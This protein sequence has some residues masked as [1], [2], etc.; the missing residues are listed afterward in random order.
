MATEHFD[1]YISYR[2][3]DHLNLARTIA[4]LLKENDLNVWFYE[5]F[6]GD[7]DRYIWLK[8][9]REALEQCDT[10]V[11]LIGPQ[12]LGRGQEQE[13]ALALSFPNIRIIPVLTPKTSLSK[14]PNVLRNHERVILS[15]SFEDQNAQIRLIDSIKN[16]PSYKVIQTQG[17]PAIADTPIDMPV[18]ILLALPN[19]VGQSGIERCFDLWNALPRWLERLNPDQIGSIVRTHWWLPELAI[20]KFG[21]FRWAVEHGLVS[22]SIEDQRRLR[23]FPG[24]DR[25]QSQ[26]LGLKQIQQIEVLHF[27]GQVLRSGLYFGGQQFMTPDI[28][29]P[30]LDVASTRLLILSVPLANAPSARG[31][32]EQITSQ[33]G[34]AVLVVADSNIELRNAYFARLYDNLFRNL[35]YSEIIKPPAELEQPG[36]QVRSYCGDDAEDLFLFTKRAY[37]LRQQFRERTSALRN[38]ALHVSGMQRE[39]LSARASS[40][41]QAQIRILGDQIGGTQEFLVGSGRGALKNIDMDSGS[42]R[43]FARERGIHREKTFDLD[44][45]LDGVVSVNIPRVAIEMPILKNVLSDMPRP[46]DIDIQKVLEEFAEKIEREQINA[47]RVLNANFANPS[48]AT[49][50]LS[51]DHSLGADREYDLRVDIGP[52]WD[53]NQSLFQDEK[54]A[55][56]PDQVVQEKLLTPEDRDRGAFD[57][58]VVFVSEQF[59]PNLAT[60]IISVPT[61]PTSRSIPYIDGQLAKEAGW[62][63]L[64]VRAPRLGEMDANAT[65]TAHGRLCLYYHNNLLQSGAIH[66]G[67]GQESGL[68][69]EKPNSGEI[70]FVLTGGFQE[71]EETFDQPISISEGLEQKVGLNLTVNDDGSGNYRI[72]AVSQLDPETPISMPAAWMPYN[73]DEAKNLLDEARRTLIEIIKPLQDKPS[74]NRDEFISDLEKLAIVGSKVRNKF[75]LSGLNIEEQ[76]DKSDGNEDELGMT[77]FQW[78]NT[79]FDKLESAAIIQVA[80]TGPASYVFPWGVLYE[81]PMEGPEYR[82]CDIIT[83]EWD[84]NGQRDKSADIS[85]PYKSEEWHKSN[86]VCPYG[87]WGLKHV[88]EQPASGLRR[89]EG[90]WRMSASPRVLTNN[91]F[92]ITLIATEDVDQD[93][94]TDHINYLKKLKGVRFEP[95]DPVRDKDKA[96]EVL[97]SPQIIYFLC[98]GEWEPKNLQERENAIPYLSIG[99]HDDDLKHK[100]FPTTLTNWSVERSL[101]ASEWAH[102]RPLVIINGCET[103]NINPK[104]EANFVTAFD[105]LGASG[106]IGTEVSM[107]VDAAYEVAE[108]ILRHLTETKGGQI[109]RAVREMRWKLINKGNLIG[110]AYTPYCRAAL[111]IENET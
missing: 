15:S 10:F 9:A 102:R 55:A 11:V 39:L 71:I 72:V 83:E 86:V 89:S 22:S 6:V 99:K 68:K 90:Q 76:K 59:S 105:Y 100:I 92:P 88:I 21:S 69:L 25:L 44:E 104:K 13:L 96:K 35:L 27:Q 7:G 12:G 61:V 47:P 58:L 66:V 91:G 84:E 80:R 52:R 26:N 97:H 3:D 19:Y 42:F 43:F 111:H 74:K 41:H 63:S 81:Y 17:R 62:A 38:Q 107:L 16:N 34:P 32:A 103:A 51:L 95:F 79:L 48:A 54:L 56:F 49:K 28:L 78:T 106:V 70:D 82:P 20:S 45:D 87:F 37:Q 57:V 77:D 24:Q 67:V 73:L 2:S 109:G 65:I 46:I 50:T 18:D 4:D 101:G 23:I 110:L 14:V 5:W 31:L 85:C 30:I 108:E 1:V 40:L 33:R 94:F 53:K 8:N 36:L 29:R 93:A 75:L 98:H 60:A 64:R